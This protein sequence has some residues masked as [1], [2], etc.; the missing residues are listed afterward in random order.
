MM[1]KKKPRAVS[2]QDQ[3][4]HLR[5][6]LK[7]EVTIDSEHNF[8]VGLSENVSEGGIFVA[9][10]QSVELGTVLDLT[11]TLPGQP[12]PTQIDMKCRVQ[13][14]RDFAAAADGLPPGLGLQFVDPSSDALKTVRDFVRRREPAFFE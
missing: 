12:Q 9:T 5:I 11:F 2:A 8:Y 6:P 3:R 13:W 4:N 1:V 7:V 14:L 10:Y